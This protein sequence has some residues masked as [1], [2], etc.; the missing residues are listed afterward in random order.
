[1]KRHLPKMH[2]IIDYLSVSLFLYCS[3][4]LIG[5]GVTP[6]IADENTRA[7]LVIFLPLLFM[8]KKLIMKVNKLLHFLFGFFR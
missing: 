3:M 4:A 1:M 8:R 2:H 7:L 5:I 6:F